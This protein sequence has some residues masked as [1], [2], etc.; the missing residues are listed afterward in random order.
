VFDTKT[1]GE[2]EHEVLTVRASQIAD[3]RR[4]RLN[5]FIED[6]LGYL[7]AEYPVHFEQQGPDAIRA[8]IERTIESAAG[9]GVTTLGAVGVLIEL[10]LVYGENLERAPDREWARNIL[11]HKKLP[12]YIKVEAV[13]NRLSEKTGGRVLVAFPGP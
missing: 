8:L 12:G 2:L 5:R 9:I 11:A 10:R 3:F 4:I 1:G 7:A 6:M 13:Q